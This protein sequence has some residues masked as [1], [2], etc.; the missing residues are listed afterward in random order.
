MSR[1][2]KCEYEC[3]S[4][5]VYD[6]NSHIDDKSKSRTQSA[7]DDARRTRMCTHPYGVADMAGFAACV[8]SVALDVLDFRR[9]DIGD[10]ELNVVHGGVGEGGGWRGM[11]RGG[12]KW[13]E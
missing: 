10:D 12:G 9:K 13:A 8:S 1:N 5:C 7:D 11:L 4:S 2:L 6:T 3:C